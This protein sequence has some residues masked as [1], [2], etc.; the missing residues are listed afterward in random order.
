MKVLSGRYCEVG[1]RRSIRLRRIVP[2]GLEARA[3]C[4][5]QESLARG[6][7]AI[8]NNRGILNAARTLGTSSLKR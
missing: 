7:F 4:L 8:L 3:T 2:H 6:T 5:R 1:R